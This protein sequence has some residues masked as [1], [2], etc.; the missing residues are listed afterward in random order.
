MMLT[1]LILNHQYVGN[2]L[3]CIRQLPTE[4]Q[5]VFS[6]LERLQHQVVAVRRGRVYRE[7]P[8][9]DSGEI[10]TTGRFFANT[11]FTKLIALPSNSGHSIFESLILPGLRAHLCINKRTI[12]SETVVYSLFPAM[13]HTGCAS[14]GGTRLM[15]RSLMAVMDKDGFTPG[16]AEII[17]PSQMYRLR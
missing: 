7:I 13:P 2:R 5:G 3:F 11:H 16:L 17:E 4:V 6:W 9:H 1:S 10:E 8:R 14:R 15:A 12:Q